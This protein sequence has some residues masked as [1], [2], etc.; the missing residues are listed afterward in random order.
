M[1]Q[2]A[3]DGISSHVLSLIIGRILRWVLEV[4]HVPL[5]RVVVMV[6]EI[7]G[8]MTRPTPGGLQ[9]EQSGV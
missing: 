4:A 8:G 1:C 2:P 3:V 6:P 5:D 7:G 9:S